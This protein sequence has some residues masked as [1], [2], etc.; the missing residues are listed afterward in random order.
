MLFLGPIFNDHDIERAKKAV[1]SGVY[2]VAIDGGA[3]LA[4]LG[5]I[6]LDYYIGDG[7]SATLEGLEYV[8]TVEGIRL[9][10]KKD[11][12]DFGAACEFAASRQISH[13]LCIGFVGGRFDH[14]VA[15]LGEAARYN[16]D[17]EFLGNEFDIFLIGR[18]SSMSVMGYETFSVIALT[19]TNSVTIEG[20]EWDLREETLM[21]FSS[22]GLSNTGDARIHVNDGRFIVVAYMDL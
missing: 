13:I 2:T 1:R 8:R 20:G 11:V 15:L 7:D 22:R 10:V 12:T 3:D 16:L 21:P 17:V 4:R 5:D 6:Q 14:Q 9:P 19:E 18:G